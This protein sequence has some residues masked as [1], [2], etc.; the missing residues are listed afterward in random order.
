MDGRKH[1][2]LGIS[3]GLLAAAG[4]H[5]LEPSLLTPA[6]GSAI[7]FGS[8]IGSVLPDMDSD[9]S[10]I[11]SMT[12]LSVPIVTISNVLNEITL[13]PNHRGFMHD[14]TFWI[15]VSILC[16]KFLP[17]GWFISILGIFVGIFSHLFADMF[18]PSGIRVF[19]IK[20]I[21]VLRVAYGS[22]M[23]LIVWILMNAFML[24]GA[25]SLAFGL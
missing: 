5:K 6:L 14:L 20:H 22:A 15:L 25:A 4:V 13:S 18:N 9:K 23:E 17:L 24:A 8:T 7:V 1:V 16:W 19:F 2:V 21:S 11:S 10:S 3:A 12:Y